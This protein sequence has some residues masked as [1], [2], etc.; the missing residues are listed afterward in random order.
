MS[1][2]IQLPSCS[3]SESTLS[4]VITGSSVNPGGESTLVSLSK[5]FVLP[6][7]SGEGDEL[8]TSESEELSDES[9]PRKI[10]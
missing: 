4:L 2:R 3:A 1:T 8:I 7:R 5:G 6:E 9:D 10:S